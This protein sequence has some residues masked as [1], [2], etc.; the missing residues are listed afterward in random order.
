MCVWNELKSVL[1]HGCELGAPE[2]ST[3]PTDITD[4]EEQALEVRE[5]RWG[6]SE[7]AGLIVEDGA[8]DRL[9]RL[10]SIW[11]MIS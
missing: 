4:L 9:I 2:K 3:T 1:I 8:S 11:I 10:E 6:E 5:L 7:E